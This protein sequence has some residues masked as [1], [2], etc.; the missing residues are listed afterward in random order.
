MHPRHPRSR[1]KPVSAA[2]F[3][4]AA[5]FVAFALQP[6]SSPMFAQ[7]PAAK[8][9]GEKTGQLLSENFDVA[10]RQYSKVLNDLAAAGETTLLPRTIKDGKLHSTGA[11]DWVSGFFPGSL[12]YLYEYTG[13]TKWRDAARDY[14]ARIESLKD[15]TGTHDL[16][17]MLY[18]SY[19]NGWRL[20]KD[21]AYRAVLLRGADSLCTR[22]NPATGAIRSWDHG[23]WS[24]PVIIDNMMNLEFLMWAAREGGNPRFR[25]IAIRHAHTT[26]A[27]HFRQDGSSFHLVDYDPVTG[28]VLTRQTVQGYA[29]T[30]AWARG[31]A[32]G[33]YGYTVM[34]RETRNPAYLEQAKKIAA[35]IIGHNRLPDDGVPYWDFD[36]PQIP[37]APRDAS[38]AAIMASAFLEL[39]DYVDERLAKRCVDTA[40]KQLLSLSSPAYRAKVG[41][42][43]GF[44]LMHSTGHAPKNSEVDVPLNYADYYFLE[45]LLRYRTKM[46]GAPVMPSAATAKPAAEKAS[47]SK[48]KK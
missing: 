10:A 45:A 31:Q 35:F 39:S 27:N 3:A 33:L 28:A 30:S 42:N 34:Y 1:T 22:Y 2:F 43:C 23:M 24:F 47:R 18:C 41:E 15:F 5:A 14:C 40:R 32:W 17:F 11:R 4:V 13:D 7:A 37:N 25:E 46:S 16:G 6:C 48:G 36:A 12:W 19:G 9:A 21:E 38:A 20:T 44:I 26:L 29:N 8:E